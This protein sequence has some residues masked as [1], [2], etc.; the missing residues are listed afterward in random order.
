MAETDNVR[1]E[2]DEN[3]PLPLAAGLAFQLVVLTISGIVLTP[4]I[5]I[6]AGGASQ[7]FT[8]WAIFA[9]LIVSGVTTILQANRVGRVGSR[10]VLLMGTSGAFIAVC[11]T[12]LSEGG[13]ALMCTLICISSFIQFVLAT[14][15]SILRRIITPTVSGVVIMLIPVTV[16]P[17]IFGLLNDIPEGFG[18][19]E[20]P[21]V[22]AITFVVGTALAIRASG[23][24]RLWTPLIGLLIGTF[25]AVLLGLF[26]FSAIKEASWVGIPKLVWPGLDFSFSPIFWS[27]LPAFLF[28]TI[29]GMIETIGDS[30]AIQRV[31]RRNPGAPDYRVVQGAVAT[32]GVGNL[33]SGIFGTVPN[34]TYSTSISVTELT[35]VASRRIGVFIG[36]FFLIIAFLPKLQATI[37]S[38]PNP[39]VG[40]YL[41]IL[42]A[43]LFVVGIKLV[44][45]DGLDFTK[46]II[47][48]VSIWVGVGFQFKL[49]FPDLLDSG[50]AL[51]TML[52]NGMTVGGLVAIGLT[53]A[54]ELTG[55]RRK[56]I[57][58]PLSTD[59][60]PTHRDFLSEVARSCKWTADD[61]NRL[62]QV[63]E[64]LIL[65]LVEEDG[66]SQENQRQVQIFARK[67]SGSIA[68][69]Y[70]ATIESE[71]L[72][73]RAVIALEAEI[74]VASRDVPLRIIH[75]LA[76]EVRHQK[77]FN[78]DI[79]SV[80][81]DASS[82]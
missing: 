67:E 30:V 20:A 16:F 22:A 74:G 61:I 69:E 3:P 2:P 27:L 24:L 59:E 51:S 42:L 40:A 19:W 77:Y 56:K 29:V 76:S 78:T 7:E 71:N 63:N 1:F 82:T 32:D 64:E 12:A 57:T 11:V 66:S 15:L 54:W 73:D 43:M 79:V 13:P 48:G 62:V 70:I 68:L 58:T 75:H 4:L 47:V 49:I 31:S 5:V 14:R 6:Q 52:Q 81:V 65:T 18:K 10:H 80:R 25:T 38:L 60:L 46:A 55:G 34:T 39:V 9:A 50:G 21:L 35:G 72:E 36:V 45:R 26:D 23:M 41:T 17:I 53:T 28:V 37:T 8:I 44:T 33:L